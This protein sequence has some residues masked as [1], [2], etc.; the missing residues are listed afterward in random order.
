VVTRRNDR[1]LDVANRDTWTVAAVGRTGGLLV[2]PACPEPGDVPGRV[3]PGGGGLRV[4]P[5][6]YV[7][8]HVELA[9]VTTAHGVQGETVRAAHLV[10]GD[11]TGAAAA[12]V[13][14]T[15]GRQ[16][17]TAHLVAAGPEEAR[18]QWIAVFAR[19]RADLGPAHAARRAAADLARHAPGRPLEQVL[20]D[21]HR[22]WTGEQRCREQLAVAQWQHDLQR[23]LADQHP[24]QPEPTAALQQAERAVAASR[25][26]LTDVRG[27]LARL[28]GEPALLALPPER[29]ARERSAWRAHQT[30]RC[31]ASPRRHGNSGVSH[32]RPEE[33]R[34]LAG[35]HDPARGI[36]R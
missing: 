2:T 10:V 29:L 4:L 28:D 1:D 13:G 34:L 8:A 35:H 16:A 9:Y 12:Y 17:N 24:E 18:G 22:A 33:L 21:L 30:A 15:R 6:D 32:P 20:A 14:M 26:E 36:P 5:E 3:T 27:R 23:A 25:Q 7:V 31:P 11:H 19:D